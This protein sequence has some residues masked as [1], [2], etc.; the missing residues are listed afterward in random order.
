LDDKTQSTT[1]EGIEHHLSAARWKWLEDLAAFFE[2]KQA[3]LEKFLN[4]R[5]SRKQ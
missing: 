3:I 1:S 2:E 5:K 4:T